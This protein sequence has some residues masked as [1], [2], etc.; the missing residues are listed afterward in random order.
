VITIGGVQLQ[1]PLGVGQRT[2]IP[3]QGCSESNALSV[4]NEVLGY[5][6]HC[7]KCGWSKVVP[8]EDQTFRDRQRREAEKAAYRSEKERTGCDLPVDFSHNLGGAGLAWLGHGG[9]TSDLI[10]YHKVGWSDRLSRVIF[11]V[12]P[13]GYIGRA[14]NPEQQPK[15][16]SKAPKGAYWLSSAT[17]VDRVCIVED[18][19]SAGRV[20]EHYPAV[21]L[22]GTNPTVPDFVLSCREVI[23]WLDGDRAGDGC[24][25]KIADH[26]KWIP[27]IKVRHIK[28]TADPKLHTGQDISRLIERALE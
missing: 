19:L 7:F 12:C 2:K 21:A 26:L 14:V 15:Y 17:P 28:T 23:L 10:R 22:L 8:H 24:R 3:H 1:Y 11:E 16:L 27:S 6:F 25:I 4:T 18:I 5:M 13:T 9:W 20:G